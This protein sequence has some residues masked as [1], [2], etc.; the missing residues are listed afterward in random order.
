MQQFHDIFNYEKTEMP[1]GGKNH[2]FKNCVILKPLGKYKV[3]DHVP[4][5]EMAINLFFWDSPDQLG[6]DE[7]VMYYP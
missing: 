6:H 4:Y 7:D 1:V 3:G 2:V 5:I